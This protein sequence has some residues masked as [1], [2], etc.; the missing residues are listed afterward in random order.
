MKENCK[1]LASVLIIDTAP[2]A[3]LS[4][5]QWR[6][7]DHCKNDELSNMQLHWPTELNA[8]CLRDV[9]NATSS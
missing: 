2:R 3:I 6:L 7:I 4:P 1:K 8:R 5:K 9:L